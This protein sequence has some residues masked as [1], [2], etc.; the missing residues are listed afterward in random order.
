MN[1]DK[2]SVELTPYEYRILNKNSLISATCK[3]QLESATTFERDGEEFVEL[4]LT[5]TELEDLTGYVAAE[6]NHARTAR[7]REDLG[8]I[9]DDFEDLIFDIKRSK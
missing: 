1:P 6:S 2:H 3:R 4:S 8:L 5:L 9:C 7:Q